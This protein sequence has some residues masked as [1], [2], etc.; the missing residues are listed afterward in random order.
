MSA[1]TESLSSHTSTRGDCSD[2]TA[3][4]RRGARCA[5]GPSAM[6]PSV[7][8]GRLR[9]AALPHVACVYQSPRSRRDDQ[10]RLLGELEDVTRAAPDVGLTGGG[11]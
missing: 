10:H 6:K 4:R 8:V 1:R 2:D 11:T 3:R 7:G 9:G 5:M